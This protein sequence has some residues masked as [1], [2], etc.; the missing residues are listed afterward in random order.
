MHG[1]RFR[2]PPSDQTLSNVTT[3][4][5]DIYGPLKPPRELRL[6]GNFNE[7]RRTLIES[8]IHRGVREGC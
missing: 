3:M 8:A 5:A 6:K 1:D 7:A 2:R 4:D